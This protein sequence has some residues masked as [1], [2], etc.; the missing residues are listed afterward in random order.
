M[1]L[2]SAMT[3]FRGKRG[4][5]S[6]LQIA[7][8]YDRAGP[9]V[10]QSPSAAAALALMQRPLQSAAGYASS[11]ARQSARRARRPLPRWLR[12]FGGP[13]AVLC[14]SMASIVPLLG[15]ACLALF[16]GDDTKVAPVTLDTSSR[17]VTAVGTGNAAAEFGL[18]DAISSLRQELGNQLQKQ[19]S[20]RL[21]TEASV[22]TRLGRLESGLSSSGRSWGGRA[23]ANAVDATDGLGVD[24][25]SW[26]GG[27]E[28]DHG[29][30]STG[31]GRGLTGRAARALS[32]LAPRWRTSV[33][34]VSPP[35]EVV[36]AAD[37]APPSTCFVMANAPGKLA[38]RLPR[39][40]YATHVAVERLP[41]WAEERP[42]A[43]PRSFEVRAWLDD[44]GSLPYA[45]VVGVFEY[46][47]AG[48]RSQA[49][50]LK[51][52]SKAI[53]A[54]QFVFDG[55][56]GDDHISVCRLRI[57]GAAVTL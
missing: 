15:I 22:M 12:N 50:E 34:N 54:V 19:E 17:A 2:L 6:D 14:A 47:L 30:T 20:A 25:A 55:S 35:P 36:L 46:K 45:A 5:Q 52:K 23:S 26:S 57:F 11:A 3:P 7:S 10:L 18:S 44:V 40:V 27:A 8:A 33:A 1:A 48:P 4:S 49:F 39:P 21:S 24:W 31:V 51:M 56:W 41:S 29:Y 43:S 42:E 32:K 37:S 13:F 38:I 9:S 16:W 53:K 28:I